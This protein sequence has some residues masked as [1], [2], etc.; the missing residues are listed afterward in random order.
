MLPGQLTAVVTTDPQTP[1]ETTSETSSSSSS[2]S[3]SLP[4]EVSKDDL[5]SDSEGDIENLLDNKC[6]RA[7]SL[8]A[9]ENKKRYSLHRSKTLASLKEKDLVEDTQVSYT[10]VGTLRVVCKHLFQHKQ[11]DGIRSPDD[12]VCEETIYFR[13]KHQVRRLVEST[14]FIGFYLVLTVY[15]LFGPDVALLHGRPEDDYG[16][17]VF[18]SVVLIFFLIELILLS[19]VQKGYVCTGHF[20]LD[21]LACVSLLGDTSIIQELMASDAVVAG[22]GSRMARM[23]RMA[24]RSSRLT[25]LTRAAR[26]ARISR[27]LPR[28][29]QLVLYRCGGGGAGDIAK[30]LITSRL[31]RIFR[32]LDEDND[33]LVSAKD[34]MAVKTMLLSGF[35]KRRSSDKGRK[36]YTKMKSLIKTACN[37]V[38]LRM[39]RSSKESFVDVE[40]AKA[41]NGD[42][43]T[44]S[45]F[46]SKLLEGEAGKHLKRCCISE[47]DRGGGFWNVTH[48]LT[49][50]TAIKVCIGVILLLIILPLLEPE[51]VDNTIQSSMAQ[52]HSVVKA[53]FSTADGNMS[54]DYDYLC[55]QVHLCAESV[56]DT[57]LLYLVADNRVFWDKWRGGCIRNSVPQKF[58]LEDMAVR[59]IDQAHLRS[60]ELIV[61]CVPE[62]CHEVEDSVDSFAIFDGKERFLEEVDMNSRKPHVVI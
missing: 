26:V 51:V 33:G 32:Y 61:A 38:I 30:I 59:M 4:G 12:S 46:S 36:P 28:I 17:S 29:Q 2:S 13:V 19:W 27:L 37:K 56:Q 34:A 47:I 58:V 52:L 14:A 31:W 50:R 40:A 24:S 18:N 5:E 6:A 54:P 44:F 60:K 23:A 8:G 53:E 57:N 45:E 39:R 25:R 9:E 49:E 48:K 1:S 16:V 55:Q 43:L 10:K 42:G 20:W 41:R 3:G 11:E 21:F 62:A 35:N 7:F 15:A 22:K